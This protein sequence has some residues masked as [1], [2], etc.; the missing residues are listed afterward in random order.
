MIIKRLPVL[1]KTEKY[2][3]KFTKLSQFYK[4]DQLFLKHEATIKRIKKNRFL[5]A[6]SIDWGFS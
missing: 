6:I 3:N 2:R 1:D 5:N 4:E